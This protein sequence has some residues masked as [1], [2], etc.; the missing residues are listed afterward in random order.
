MKFKNKSLLFYIFVLVL[1]LLNIYNNSFQETNVLSLL[2]SLIGL[3]G[4]IVYIFNPEKSK[5]FILVWIYSQLFLISNISRSIKNGQIK[6]NE[7]SILDLTQVFKIQFSLSFDELT[8]AINFLAIIY[9]II[10]FKLNIN[11]KH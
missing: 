2:V 10:Y 11:I 6:Q 4:V 5:I 1:S 8:F 3:S 9:L 7:Y